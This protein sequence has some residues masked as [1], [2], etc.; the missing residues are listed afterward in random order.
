[1]MLLLYIINIIAFIVLS[2]YTPLFYT[3]YFKLSFYNP[4]VLVFLFTMP[5]TLFKTFI[6]PAFVLEDGIFN[7]YFHYALLMTN[8]QLF[9]TLIVTILLTKTF[10]KRRFSEKFL[11]RI[12]P[13]WKTSSKRM[14]IASI[15]FLILFFISF[16]ILASHSFGLVN[17]IKS[18]RTG[19][20]FH[21]SGAGQ[22]FAFALLF[23][24]TSYTLRLIY[25]KK[26]ANVIYATIV[27]LFFVW[28]MGSK[29]FMLNFCS[30][31]LI[32]LW[33]RRYKHIK[34]I[35]I[36]AIPCIFGLLLMNFGSINIEEITLYFDYYINSANYYEAY[37]NK[38]IDLFYGEIAASNF[39]W[40]VPRSLYPDKPYVYGLLLVNEHFFPGAAEATHT[41]A[42]GGPIGSFADFGVGGVIFDSIFNMH[43]FFLSF[44]YYLI[45]SNSQLDVIRKNPILIYVMLIL[46]APSF[47]N[48]IGFPLSLFVFLMIIFV[49]AMCNRCVVGKSGSRS[50]NSNPAV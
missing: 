33:F 45:F 15:F 32:I 19:Y 25:T 41:P 12:T 17:W 27:Y 4:T 48:F 44:C 7:K 10:H 38:E 37:F 8:V 35:L 36:F 23:L 16:V 1:M 26:T 9:F 28:F 30:F 5:I 50:I 39:W 18:P 22:Y 34:K 31:T 20:Q 21:R 42:Y 29:N 43:T 14:K 3:R 40:M 6:G 2:C 24:S 13:K 49:I 47:M 46:F 11:Q